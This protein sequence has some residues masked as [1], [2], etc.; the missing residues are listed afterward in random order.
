L[1][2]RLIQFI[3]IWYVGMVLTSF[4]GLEQGNA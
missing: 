2:K 3:T 4:W 1:T